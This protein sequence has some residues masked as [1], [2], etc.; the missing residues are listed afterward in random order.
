MKRLVLILVGIVVITL[1]V[2]GIIIFGNLGETLEGITPEI[3]E[4]SLNWGKVT[5]DTTEIQGTA[6]VFNP[7]SVPIP[8]DSISCEITIN[9]IQIGHGETIGLQIEK[10]KEFPVEFSAIFNNSKFAEV[11]AE[12]IMLSEKSEVSIKLGV[13][14]DLGISTI[15]IPFTI[16]QPFVT[17]LLS[18]LKQVNPAIVEKKIQLPILGE[19]SIFKISFEGL[20]GNWGTT[21]PQTSQINLSAIIH[22]EN[23][24]PLLVPK[25]KCTIES[26]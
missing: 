13:T 8:I 3:R 4:V 6:K 26:N 25:V 7:N 22:N 2:V 16:N 17:D 20:T 11:W 24:Y 5:D 21:T 23:P 9:G 1:V 18:N 10:N 19:K 14:V 12:H 15:T